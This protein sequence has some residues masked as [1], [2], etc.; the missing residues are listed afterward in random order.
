MK[1]KSSTLALVAIALLTVGGLYL[2]QRQAPSADTKDGALAGKP[3]FQFKETDITK[4]VIQQP[5]Q[6]LSLTKGN[7]GWQIVAPKPGPADEGTVTFLLNLLATG[8]SEKTLQADAKQLSEFGLTAKP[9]TIDVTLKNQKSHRVVLGNQTFDQGSV[10]AR[11]DPNTASGA[12]PVAIV[13]TNFLDAVDRP[14]AE[15]QAKPQ[16]EASP[17]IPIASPSP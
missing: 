14:L 15:W 13:P 12:V 4:V 8:T 11:V 10:Y 6:T 3:L 1:L 5:T 2:W 17:K 9:T 16:L 7:K